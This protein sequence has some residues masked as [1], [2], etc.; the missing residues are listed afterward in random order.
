[1][2]LFDLGACP[3]CVRARLKLPEAWALRYF[4]NVVHFA[5]KLR[6]LLIQQYANEVLVALP[7]HVPGT[8]FL[9]SPVG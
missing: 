4:S 1:M 7:L 9:L 3:F 6:W 2:P 8:I 5:P